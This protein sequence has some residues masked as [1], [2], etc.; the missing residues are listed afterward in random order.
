MLLVDSFSNYTNKIGSRA[1]QA[2]KAELNPVQ[3]KD[4]A[5]GAR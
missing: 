2:F 1:T 4:Q 3:V 5:Y